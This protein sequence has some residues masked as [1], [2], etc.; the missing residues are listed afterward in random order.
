MRNIPDEEVSD[1][2]SC[3][4]CK[5]AKGVKC[6]VVYSDDDLWIGG[7]HEARYIQYMD[8]VQGWKS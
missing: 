6:K 3:R 7:V 1:A 4:I 8:E 2:V 5:V